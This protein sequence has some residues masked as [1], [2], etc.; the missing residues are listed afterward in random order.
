[1]KMHPLR[2]LFLAVLLTVMVDPGRGQTNPAAAP[3]DQTFAPFEKWKSMVLAG[4]AVGLKQLY[5]TNPVAHIITASG[6]VDAD[7]AVHYW[8]GIKAR[9]MKFEMVQNLSPQP[10]SQQLA[11]EAEILSAATEPEKTFYITEVQLWQKEGQDWRLVVSKRS[12]A[13]RLKQPVTAKKNLYDGNADAH[14]EVKDALAKAAKENKRV[15]L[16]FGANWCYDCHVLDLAFERPDIAPVLEANYV[17]AHIDIGQGDKNQDLMQQYDVPS[18]RGIP[19]AAVLD[20]NGKLLYSQKK[21]EF[22]KARELGP[23]DLLEF[24]NKWKLGAG[25]S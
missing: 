19:A 12:D 5:S 6:S 7:A 8:I 22:E 14:A 24:L 20:A 1:M 16:V 13:S 25:K 3:A 18:E 23:E 17:V 4:D 10:D 15:L 21:G 11:F 9:D 2:I